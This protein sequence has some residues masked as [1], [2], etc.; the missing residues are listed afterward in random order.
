MADG[1]FQVH[2]SVSGQ[3]DLQYLASLTLPLAHCE[4]VGFLRGAWT[5]EGQW[6]CQPLT[7]AGLHQQSRT[8]AR[9]PKATLGLPLFP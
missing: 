4:R 5:R 2:S 1:V 8:D 7:E 9:L 3:C 6:V